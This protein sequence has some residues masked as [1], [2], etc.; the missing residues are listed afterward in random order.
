MNSD[1]IF[2]IPDTPQRKGLAYISH[3]LLTKVGDRSH[4]FNSDY[5]RLLI[6]NVSDETP[7]FEVVGGV[8][9]PIDVRTFMERFWELQRHP[10]IKRFVPYEHGVAVL[11]RV[12][13]VDLRLTTFDTYYGERH[14]KL[15]DRLSP[16]DVVYLSTDSGANWL[17]IE[18]AIDRF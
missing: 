10:A 3:Y 12:T 14:D 17:S 7:Y 9:K 2:H 5:G 13:D 16:G 11:A 15:I 8:G 1:N 6:D 18:D 4:Q